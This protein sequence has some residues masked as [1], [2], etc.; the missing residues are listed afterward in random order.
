VGLVYL[1]S[2]I[3]IVPAAIYEMAVLSSESMTL[4]HVASSSWLVIAASEEI[5]KFAAVWLLAYHHRSFSEL[6][7]GILY[8]VAASLGFATAENIL[9]V[10][11]PEMGGAGTAVMRALLS[12]PGHALWGVMMGYCLGI[13][14]FSKHPAARRMYMAAGVIVAIFWHG[15]YD[16]FAF[17]VEVVPDDQ[18][19][20]FVLGVPVT[21]IVC[22]IIALALL[23]RAQSQ[24]V[25]KRP[26]PMVNPVAAV[27]R[28][29][30]YCIHCGKPV[31][32]GAV[33]C[34]RCGKPLRTIAAT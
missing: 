17:G 11:S 13:A 25:Y 15:L 20:L 14:R 29:V 9:Y 16:F 34:T 21:V 8:S 3:T 1:A 28:R 23:R 31:S 4:V 10:L 19:A 12:V 33:F 2:F 24:S 22:W 18:A 32:I 7:D 5:A 26:S 30:Q 6:Y 27:N